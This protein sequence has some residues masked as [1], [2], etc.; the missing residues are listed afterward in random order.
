LGKISIKAMPS[1]CKVYINGFLLGYPPVFEQPIVAGEHLI[2]FE[3]SKF[4]KMIEKKV[5]VNKDK[6]S[7][8]YE[9]LKQ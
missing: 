8:V 2:K 4:N 9:E 1:S 5:T 3:W 7:Y 6:V